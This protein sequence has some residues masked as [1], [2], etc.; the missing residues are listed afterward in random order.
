MMN[1]LK[2]RKA[3]T[4][5]GHALMVQALCWAAMGIGM[6]VTTQE[7]ALIIHAIA[8]PIIAVAVSSVYFIK[9]D[10][11]TPLQTAIVFLSVV[12]AMDF[13]VVALLI[14]KSLE[15]FTS[16]IGT[17]IPLSSI[18]LLTYLTGLYTK[19]HIETTTVA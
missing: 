10:Y 4:V 12:L 8:A 9:F 18:F 6:A 7:N 13:F 3:V 11:T 16:P 14:E 2:I 15:M 5:L 1:T 19:K 17:W